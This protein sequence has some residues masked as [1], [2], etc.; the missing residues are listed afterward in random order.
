TRKSRVWHSGLTSAQNPRATPEGVFVTDARTNARNVYLIKNGTA[1][2]VSNTLTDIET[3]DF[4]PGRR[5]IVV[6]ELSADG[7]RLKALPFKEQRPPALELS[8][9]PPPPKAKTDK[10]KFREENYLPIAYMLPRYWIP[11]VYQV[12]DGLIFQGLT[13]HQDP[14][15]RNHYSLLASYDT[16]TEI[17]SYG[18]SYVNSSLP[19]EIGLSYARSVSYLG[20]SG[21]TLEN[22]SAGLAFANRW[23]FNSRYALWSIG[24][25][26]DETE[27]IVSTYKRMGPEFTWTYSK[28]SSPTVDRLGVHAE[29]SH[30]EYLPQDDYLDYG[31]S[32]AFLAAQLDLWQ[33]HKAMLQTRAALS[34]NMPFGHVIDLGERTVGGN[35]LI[36][37]ANSQFLLRGYPSGTFVGRKAV[38]GNFEYALP[39]LD[40]DRGLGS[41][42]LFFR[43]LELAFFVDTMAVDGAGYRPDFN[44]YTRS[45]LREFYTGTGAELR[46]ATTTAYHLPLSLTLGAYYGLNDRFGGG[47]TPF[48][49][50]GFGGLSALENKTP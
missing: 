46:L 40:L 2:P 20:A 38:S 12:E 18:F 16:V 43:S 30:R 47:F 26:W 34:P 33:G 41:F 6:S 24:G 3:F 8:K 37:L 50:I 29:L 22:Q 23:P 7:R 11:F 10:V 27:G 21:L 25:V 39:A 5:E 42:P 36:N 1:K 14:A 32:Y 44:V 28:L 4:D 45:R 35:Y 9:L 13:S 15:G 17:P 48:L 31:R 49:G 19:T